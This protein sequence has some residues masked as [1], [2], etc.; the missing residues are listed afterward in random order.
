[1]KIST[2]LLRNN[3]SIPAQVSTSQLTDL[4]EDIG[5]EVKSCSTKDNDTIMNMEFLSNRGDHRSYVGISREIHGRT[6]WRLLNL[7]SKKNECLQPLNRK[8]SINSDLC[9]KYSLVEITLDVKAQVSQNESWGKILELSSNQ[10]KSP[11]ID[12]T[13]VVN[14]EL[15]QPMHAFDADKVLG[16]IT[17]RTSRKDEEALLLNGAEKIILEAGTL[18]IADAEKILAIAGVMGCE[19]SKVD[20]KTTKILLESACF[21]PES[22]RKTSKTLG[23]QSDSSL[24]FERGGDWNNIEKSLERAIYLF[25]QI[26]WNP[27]S[28]NIILENNIPE[29]KSIPFNLKAA[30]NFFQT[31]LNTPYIIEK[32]KGYGFLHTH[33]NYKN[34]IT[35]TVPSNRHWDIS[36]STDIYEE[37]AK[38]IGYNNLPKNAIEGPHRNKSKKTK[39]KEAVENVLIHNGFFEVFTNGFYSKSLK[40]TLFKSEPE[41]NLL[42]NHVN[43]IDSKEKSYELLKNN[44]FAYI[45]SLINTNTNNKNNPI[46]A[47]E[48]SKNFIADNYSENGFCTEEDVLW[49]VLSGNYEIPWRSNKNYDIYDLKGVIEKIGLAL[50]IKFEFKQ[51]KDT[52]DEKE[53]P[54]LAFLHPERRALIKINGKTYG[55]IGEIHPK[56][57]NNFSLKKCKP[58][59]FEI[60]SNFLK[61][62]PGKSRYISPKNINITKK[63]T[64][65][66]IPFGM[67]CE[68]VINQIKSYSSAIENVDVVDVFSKN[69]NENSFTFRISFN[70]HNDQSSIKITEEI[71]SEMELYISNMKKNK[72][73][74]HE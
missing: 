11:Q 6:G 69:Y 30:N 20:E 18:V 2:E 35:I 48:W 19:E 12:I 68:E 37:I 72:G 51:N 21:N 55:F 59:M 56:T 66:T 14:L 73:G 13:N 17:I 74:S 67:P 44:S 1:M 36:N 46:K 54:A 31:N 4:L 27:T 3:I 7:S 10:Q 43:T 63:D 22:I 15:G 45:L 62:I 61:E 52:D 47:F 29:K 16:D 25:K 32:L 34:T 70:F 9:I 49:G 40:S 24:R 58:C 26:G 23:I 8:I 57:L 60:N 42:F 53:F 65:L 71:T 39:S 38:S 50:R 33:N 28:R 5:I 64:T 41:T